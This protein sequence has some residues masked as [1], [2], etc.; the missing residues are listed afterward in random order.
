MCGDPDTR[1]Q[2][3]LIFKQQRTY[4]DR[5]SESYAGDRTWWTEWDGK[6]NYHNT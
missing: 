3:F 6:K 2:P 1:K 4:G 5:V